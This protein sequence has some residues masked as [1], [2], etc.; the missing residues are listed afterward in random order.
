MKTITMRALTYTTLLL[1]LAISFSGCDPDIA[2][3]ND[4]FP[5]DND[6]QWSY[7]RSDWFRTNA[8]EEPVERV[9][10]TLTLKIN[11]DVTIGG[12]TYKQIVDSKNLYNKAIR[13]EGSK[14]YARNHEFYSNDFS[15]EYVFL[16]TDKAVGESWS[17]IKDDGYSKTEYIVLAKD[18]TKSILKVEYNDVI[19]LKVNYYHK[20]SQGEYEFWLSSLHS[21]S[22]GIGEVYSFNPYP[23]SGRYNDVSSNIIR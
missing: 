9:S 16:D 2:P 5:L 4:Y 13:V 19:E 15:H 6:R 12:K 8:S 14:Y 11:G 1:L 18:V 20:N 17:Y 3:K 22:A 21:Y 7:Q 10:D 23:I